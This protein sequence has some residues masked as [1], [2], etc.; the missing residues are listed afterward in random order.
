M[1]LAAASSLLLA[2]RLVHI[3]EAGT[4]GRTCSRRA[5]AS[6]LLVAGRLVAVASA[7]PNR[8]RAAAPGRLLAR[9]LVAGDSPL[10]RSH[11]AVGPA[12]IWPT[13]APA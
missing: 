10:R 8:R 7:L 9:L 13:T 5:T 12:G 3:A 4:S 6:A 2:V 1:R 11:G